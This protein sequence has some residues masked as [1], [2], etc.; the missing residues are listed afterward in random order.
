VWAALRSR[1]LR[2]F[3]RDALEYTDSTVGRAALICSQCGVVADECFYDKDVQLCMLC[4][5]N[6]LKETADEG[7]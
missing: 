6:R 7:H 3:G 5:F 2:R 1:L 4:T